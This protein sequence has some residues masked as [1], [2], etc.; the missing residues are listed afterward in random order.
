MESSARTIAVIP[1]YLS[2]PHHPGQL[3]RCVG[4]L[5]SGPEPAGVVVVDDGS[6]LAMPP[7]PER[8]EVVRLAANAGPAAARNRGLERGLSLGAEVVLFTDVDCVPAPGWAREMATFLKAGPYVAAGGVTQSLGTTLLNRY[9]DFAGSLN[10][11]WLLPER[12]ELVYA[13]TCNMAVRAGALAQ[14]RF[15]ERFPAAAGEDVDFCLRLRAHGPIGLATRAVVRHDFGYPGTWRG[16]EAFRRMFRRYGEA[17]PL[18]WDKH[19]ELHRAPSEACAAADLLSPE[20]SVDP[21]AYRRAASS[22]VRPRRFR[23]AMVALRWIARQAYRSGQARPRAWRSVRADFA[24][25]AGP[26]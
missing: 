8:V 10:G 7:L 16:L 13:A 17:D 19:P 23:P 1:A 21:A 20:P 25:P 2:R 14:V 4:A 9:H 26:V 18:I 5:L 12:K 11:R 24:D 22:R 3:T 15:D 6:P